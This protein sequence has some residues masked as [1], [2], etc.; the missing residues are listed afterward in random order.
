[1]ASHFQADCPLQLVA[2]NPATSDLDVSPHGAFRFGNQF[3]VLRG[4]TLTTYT[5]TALGDLQIA[6]EDFLGS[7][8]A[9]E[10]NGGVAFNGGFLYI[11]SDAGLEIYDLRGVRAGGSAPSLI[12]RTANVHYRRMASN[13]TILAGI[14]PATDYPCYVGGPTPN[15]INTIDLWDVSNPAS[16]MRVNTLPSNILG[17]G[18]FNDV[19]FNYGYL[20]VTAQNGTRSFD[21]S[22]PLLPIFLG[23]DGVA[24]TFLVSNGAGL[25][26]VGNQGAILT[27]SINPPGPAPGALTE[28]TLHTLAT[29]QTER[30]N[31]I[32]FHPQATFDDQSSRLI[33]MVDELDPQ[34]LQPARTF[35]FDVF[36]YSVPMFEGSDPR[37]YEQV[38]YTQGDEVK[39]N[40]LSIGP[41][42]YVIGAVSGLQQYG[43]CGSMAGHIDWN[44]TTALSCGGAQVHGWVTGATKIANVEVFL[45]GG[46][47]GSAD[48]TGPP[49]LDVPSSTPVQSWRVNVNLDSTPKGLHTLRAVG[50][51]INGNQFQFASQ[52]VFF[53]GPGQNCFQRRRTSGK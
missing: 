50:T 3:F 21:I 46:S 32:M 44:G 16:P 11:S 6:R 23:S 39:Y 10:V 24:G 33:T 36:D 18:G 26:A 47:L 27:L 14:F 17:F 40:P 31:P 22:N 29:L 52:D 35:A 34:T 9:R 37:Q 8:G 1:M 45:D 20:V 25:V 13:G 42:V 43:S 5:V 15:C 4:Q 12:S 30:A 28:V 41:N 7:L 2:S 49:R 53:N 38:S 48:M 51:D 19:A